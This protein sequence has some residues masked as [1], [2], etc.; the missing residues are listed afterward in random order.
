LHEAARPTAVWINPRVNKPTRQNAQ[1]GGLTHRPLASQIAV[2]TGASSGIGNAIA[3]ALGNQGAT[4]CLLGRNVSALEIAAPQVTKFK[5]DLAE[6]TQIHDVVGEVCRKLGAVDILVHS[7]GLFMANRFD[8]ASLTDFDLQY[9][10][11]VRAPYLLT[12][13]LLPS[14]KERRGQVVFINSSVARNPA[15]V[16][17]SQYAATKT[18][19]KV[20]ADSL[21]NEVNPAGVRVLTVFVGRCA[22][23]MQ[24][25][26][27]RAEGKEYRPEQLLQPEDIASVVVNALSLPRTAEITDIDIRPMQKS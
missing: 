19:L 18:A 27:H 1:G 9:R 12:Q 25:A 10:L 14:L 22:T 15:G 7:A 4:L 11:N 26:I 17:L 8:V 16:G 23:P 5:V 3:R 20:I 24:A 13:E 21:R 2:V 6:E